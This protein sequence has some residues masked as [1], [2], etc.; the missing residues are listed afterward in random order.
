M[1]VSAKI[2]SKS[3]TANGVFARVK[4]EANG[5]PKQAMMR[6]FDVP[7][8]DNFEIGQKIEIGLYEPYKNPVAPTEQEDVIP[9]CMFHCSPDPADVVG[10]EGVVLD[11]L[12]LPADVIELEYPEESRGQG[13][14][15]GGNPWG[16]SG[17]ESPASEIGIAPVVVDEGSGDERFDLDQILLPAPTAENM[18]ERS[19][20]NGALGRL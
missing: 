11:P 13:T 19:D 14:L 2:V 18:T 4:V 15:P 8:E 10:A 12:N 9:G 1:K 16:V 5:W 17:C 20:S 7:D 3:I 6:F